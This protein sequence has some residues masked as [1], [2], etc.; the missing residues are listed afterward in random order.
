MQHVLVIVVGVRHTCDHESVLGINSVG[1]VCLQVSKLVA[2][3]AVV[4]RTDPTI[5]HAW[6]N[7]ELSPMS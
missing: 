6:G 4:T 5:P 7:I 2:V 1:L 3:H